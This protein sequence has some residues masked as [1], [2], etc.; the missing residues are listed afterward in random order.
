M[1]PHRPF[2]PRCL[3]AGL[4]VSWIVAIYASA[5]LLAAA[6][7]APGY[8]GRPVGE[9]VW[10]LTDAI[11]VQAK[12][13]YALASTALLLGSRAVPMPRPLRTAADL[14]LACMAMLTVLALLPA[15]WSQGF[16]TGLTGARFDPATLPRYLA[17]A[18]LSGLTFSLA[19]WRCGELAQLTPEDP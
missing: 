9:A 12:L 1:R 6:D 18:I 2:R 13:A 16:G 4:V 17:A 5:A 15:D 8:R 10:N 19:D 14:I 3:A 11:S 7:L